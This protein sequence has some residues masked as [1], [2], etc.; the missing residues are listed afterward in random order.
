MQVTVVQA[1]QHLASRGSRQVASTARTA[2]GTGP[3]RVELE[4]WLIKRGAVGL[5]GRVSV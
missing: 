5:D 2:L 3:T 4:P 1:V